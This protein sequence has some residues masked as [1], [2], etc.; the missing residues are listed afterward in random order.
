MAK[1]GD[2]V[3]IHS[4]ILQPGERAAAVPE[5]TKQVPLEQW[6]KGYLQ[7]DAALGEEASVVTRTGRL[8]SGTLVDETPHYT[9]SFG[10]FVPELQ[11]AGDEA[12]RF[13]FGGHCE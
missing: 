8:V 9:H 1:K 12:F 11:Q 6:T 10:D 7:V 2:W 3:R 13:L 4:V 5:D